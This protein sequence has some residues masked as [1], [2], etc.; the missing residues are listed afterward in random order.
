MFFVLPC[1]ALSGHVHPCYFLSPLGMEKKTL[2]VLAWNEKRQ[3]SWA[4]ITACLAGALKAE[5]YLVPRDDDPGGLAV[6]EGAKGQ[7]V[8]CIQQR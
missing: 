7:C 6:P 3:V 4:P 5:L 2:L 8:F 1:L